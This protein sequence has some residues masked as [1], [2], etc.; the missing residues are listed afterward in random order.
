MHPR[1]ECGRYKDIS[2]FGMRAVQV[3]LVVLHSS[4]WRA[5]MISLGHCVGGGKSVE[6][7]NFGSTYYGVVGSVIFTLFSRSVCWDSVGCT[8]F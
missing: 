2:I 6:T 8:I 4:P 3:V 1:D 5:G 7:T